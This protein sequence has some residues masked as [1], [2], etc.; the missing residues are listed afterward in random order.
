MN[1]VDISG[2][3]KGILTIIGISIALGQFGKLEHLARKQA[4]EALEWK[5][6][7]PYF[8]EPERT[9]NHTGENMNHHSNSK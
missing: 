4:M 2:L 7:L 8:F 3:V 6:G 9:R 1:A 5:Q